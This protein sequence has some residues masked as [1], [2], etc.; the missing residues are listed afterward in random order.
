[1]SHKTSFFNEKHV[2]FSP[3]I[4]VSFNFCFHCKYTRG[5]KVALKRDAEET[6]NWNLLSVFATSCAFQLLLTQLQ[7][8]KSVTLLLTYSLD[9]YIIW[10]VVG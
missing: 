10:S 7:V 8:S 6:L 9:C 3:R 5:G 1:L 4:I 2:L